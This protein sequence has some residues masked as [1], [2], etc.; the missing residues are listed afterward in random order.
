M[1]HVVCR[2]EKISSGGGFSGRSQHN[3]RTFNSANINPSL[4][5]Q[6]I[7][8]CECNI[9]NLD[10]YLS[11]KTAQIKQANK[12]RKV[13]SRS[14]KVGKAFATEF[15]I[16]HSNNAMSKNE[17]IEYLKKSYEFIKNRYPDQEI[18]QGEIHLDETTPHIH[19]IM[20]FYNTKEQKWNQ[21][22]LDLDYAK[23]Q[24]DLHQKVGKNFGLDRGKESSVAEH[25]K[26]L[27]PKQVLEVKKEVAQKH[28]LN[29]AK[30]GDK[31]NGE[32][33]KNA[34]NALTNVGIFDRILNTP[35]AQNA[36]KNAIISTPSI[37]NADEQYYKQHAKKEQKRAKQAVKTVHAVKKQLNNTQKQLNTAQTQLEQYQT[38]QNDYNALKQ[39]LLDAQQQ[40]LAELKKRSEQYAQKLNA[41]IKST[42]APLIA[43][44]KELDTANKANDTANEHIKSLQKDLQKDL[45]KKQE[46][47]SKYEQDE[48]N[49]YYRTM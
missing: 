30:N 23:L 7:T 20:S 14:L 6:N 36:V 16:S 38:L 47:L 18:L 33:N 2:A 27:T 41:V 8:L 24:T 3:N 5:P 42:N 32:A 48:D 22:N 13:N 25:K 11:A 34:K 43:K 28:S 46:E 21:R 10:S 19:I 35:K 37:L 44:Q 29:I 9:K 4:T 26:S 39:A 40:H 15:V 31:V 17:S 12:T 1:P 49:S 45:Q